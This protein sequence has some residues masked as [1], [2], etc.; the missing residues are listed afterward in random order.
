LRSI[1]YFPPC[2]PFSVL[3]TESTKIKCRAKSVWQH[4]GF[5]FRNTRSLSELYT[6]FT[7]RAIM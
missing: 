3:F 4:F 5:Q 2:S 7:L 6:E 1:N